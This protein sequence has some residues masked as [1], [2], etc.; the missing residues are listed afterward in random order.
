MKRH[1]YLILLALADQDRHGSAIAREVH[2]LSDGDLTLWPVTLYGSLA[3][4]E[5]RK[6]IESL[7]GKGSRPAG[8]SERKRYFR[9]SRA[10]RRA[11]EAE[12]RRL[13][14]LVAVAAGRLSHGGPA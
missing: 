13:A 7:A 1:L 10:G 4:L 14:S 6:W 2:R 9:L 11:V 12:T 3:E 5:E 8:E